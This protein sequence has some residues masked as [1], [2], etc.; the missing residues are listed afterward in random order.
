MVAAGQSHLFRHAGAA[1]QRQ[2]GAT[3]ADRPELKRQAGG[4]LSGP[5]H[6]AL[7]PQ[8]QADSYLELLSLGYLTVQGDGVNCA[9]PMS[10]SR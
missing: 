6:F 5:E 10:P 7:V 3:T 2:F 4:E 9:V 1:P 8:G